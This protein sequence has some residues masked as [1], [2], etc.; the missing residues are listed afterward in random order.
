[1]WKDR[2]SYYIITVPNETIKKGFEVF[3]MLKELDQ[4]NYNKELEVK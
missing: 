3:K 1:M 4:I 2:L